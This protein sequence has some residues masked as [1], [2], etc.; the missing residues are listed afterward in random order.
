MSNED[1]PG[2]LYIMG[3]DWDWIFQRPQIIERHLEETNDVTVIFPRSILKFFARSRSDYPQ[4]YKILWTLPLQEKIKIIGKISRLLNR[5]I[6]R[7]IQKYE[8]IVIGYPLYYR[9][10]PRDYPGMLI[11]DC[12]DNHETLYCCRSG[13]QELLR[14]EKALI[15]HSGLVFASSQQLLEKLQKYDIS[16]MPRMVLLRNGAEAP[17]GLSHIARPVCRT[18]YKIGYIGTIAE[19]FDRDLI[20][21]SLQRIS[22]IEYH[23]VGPISIVLPD[24]E[25]RL[26]AE[27]IVPHDL[28]YGI[29][30]SYC[31]LVMPFRLDETV[32]CVD[33]VKLYEYI[34]MGKCIV[35]VFYPEIE[36]F[37][38]FVYFYHSDTDYIQLLDSLKMKGFPPKYT[39]RQ[40]QDFLEGNSWKVR[41]ATWDKAVNDRKQRVF[42]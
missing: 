16:P 12:M 8:T 14:Q 30:Q 22:D 26:I 41:F 6:F 29:A 28:L 11:Y 38:D 34:A 32:L 37:G 1:K 24:N 42:P 17:E 31:C 7:D 36:R 25:S 35:A 19:W 5:H 27:G 39:S 18:R 33:P 9:Y 4:H 23:L 40:R 20:L 15:A 2:L 13:V 3:I 10:I 21:K